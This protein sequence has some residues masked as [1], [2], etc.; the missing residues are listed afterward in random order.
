MT[1]YNPNLE[2]RA[3]LYQEAN[4]LEPFVKNFGSLS[5]L[6]EELKEKT[7]KSGYRYRVT[8]MVAPES[9]DMQVQA[10]DTSL[11]NAAK[12]AKEE[13]QRQLNALVNA[14]PANSQIPREL[15]H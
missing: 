6:V 3:F 8:F 11:Y 13:A 1:V 4:D 10:T 5:V 2:E 12:A 9:V 7:A 15:L 14:M